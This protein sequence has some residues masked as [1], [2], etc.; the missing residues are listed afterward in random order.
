MNTRIG[1]VMQMAYIV[2]N[3][4]DAIR[5]FSRRLGIG[6]WFVRRRVEYVHCTYR[7]QPTDACVS[8]AFAYS[9]EINFELLQLENDAPSIFRDFV[10][11]H[12]YGLQHVGVLTDDIERDT[13]ALAAEG[14]EMLMHMINRVGVDTRLFDTQFMPGATLELIASSPG[15]VAGFANMRQA[16]ADWDGINAV[17]ENLSVAS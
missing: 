13:A 12:G 4:D 15:I 9:G 2:E 8:L 10:D 7:G 17:A 3:L 11:S 6:P 14:V 5:D 16:A 1:P